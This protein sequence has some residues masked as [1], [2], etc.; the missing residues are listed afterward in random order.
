MKQLFSRPFW[1][2]LILIA[3]FAVAITLSGWL[4][5]QWQH[6]Q[7]LLQ[8]QLLNNSASLLAIQ[9]LQ[10][11]QPAAL[12]VTLQALQQ[13]SALPIRAMAVFDQ[14][15]RVF[16]ST[17]KDQSW[18]EQAA[19]SLDPEQSQFNAADIRLVSTPIWAD[20]ALYV[21]AEQSANNP[22]DRGLVT[23]PAVSSRQLGYLL[24]LLDAPMTPALR[25]LSPLFGFMLL[26]VGLIWLGIRQIL[27]RQRQQIYDLAQQL[28]QEHPGSAIAEPSLQPLQ[29]AWLGKMQVLRQQAEVVKQ[30][31]LTQLSQL[32]TQLQLSQ[33]T[34]AQLSAKQLQV[35]AQLQ[36]SL[37]LLDYWRQVAADAER[38]QTF[39]LIRHMKLFALYTRLNNQ[40]FML[41]PDSVMLPDL[42]SHCYEEY[43]RLPDR[44]CQFLFEEDPQAYAFKVNLD[45]LLLAQLLGLLAGMCSQLA[46]EPEILISYRLVEMPQK[47]LKVNLKFIGPGFPE[48]WRQVLATGVDK[49][50]AEDLEAEVCRSILQQLQGK[51][52]ID[53]IADVGTQLEMVLPVSWQKTNATKR[54]QSILLV[55]EKECRLP[56]AKQSLSALGEQVHSCNSYRLL[57]DTLQ[58]RLVDFLVLVLPEQPGQFPIPLS[59]LNVLQQRMQIQ[60]LTHPAAV[61][62][63][64]QQ[65]SFPVSA[66]PLL[67]AQ[68]SKPASQQLK[69][70]Q[71]L[72]VDDNLTNLSYVKAVLALE[73]LRI[74]IAMTGEEAIKMAASN[75]Y[76][77]ILM[78]IQ[79]PDVPGTEVTKQIRQLRHHQQTVILAFTAHALPDEIA[80]FRLAGMDDVLIKPLDTQKIA[81]ILGRI[82]ALDQN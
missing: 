65:L 67:I 60:A 29:T 82:K 41:Q 78:D 24:V 28:G 49:M 37:K 36:A 71:L 35:N 75:R 3:A 40:E 26:A 18:L 43:I 64:Q 76:Q 59:D 54:F 58:R 13:H 50:L 14:S 12:E 68:L 72:V 63:W 32:E 56:L 79:L 27:Q 55:D 51:L 15:Q 31:H 73:G 25:V 52:Q 23:A 22:A 57:N 17:S 45:P 7:T 39:P 70:Q 16:A 80:G 19:Q 44:H 46:T 2:L 42:M 21:T 81:H 10:Q 30:E 20:R 61:D 6:Q 11:K 9:P 53:S 38:Q 48:R 62:L 47:L 69:Q 5:Q 77:L 74:D 33:Q 34:S 66:M 8:I 1:P 4:L